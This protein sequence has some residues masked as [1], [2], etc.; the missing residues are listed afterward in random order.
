MMSENP[1][2]PPKKPKREL[3]RWNE[4]IHEDPVAD[5]GEFVF[6]MAVFVIILFHPLLIDLV[7]LLFEVNT[8]G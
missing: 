4:T 7:A 6:I 5:W 2:D 3:D 8:N 1:Y